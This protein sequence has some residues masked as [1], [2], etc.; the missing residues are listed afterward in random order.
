MSGQIKFFQPF[1]TTKGS[2]NTATATTSSTPVTASQA[3]YNQSHMT[4]TNA[5]T[6]ITEFEE[7]KTIDEW[8]K[9]YQ[10]I[11]LKFILPRRCN[12]EHDDDGDGNGG[13]EDKE[14]LDELYFKTR[15]DFYYAAKFGLI[16]MS[17]A[18]ECVSQTDESLQIS[19]NSE[20]VFSNSNPDTE[21]SENHMD[22]QALHTNILSP[23]DARLAVP[24][25]LPLLNKS[26]NVGRKHANVITGRSIVPYVES[27]DQTV[28]SISDISLSVSSVSIG[29]A[30]I[31]NVW[32][33]QKC[34]PKD[35]TKMLHQYRNENNNSNGRE[36][37]TIPFPYEWMTNGP[38][39]INF[40]R[41]VSFE[42]MELELCQG[43]QQKIRNLSR[44]AFGQK[45][46]R[47]RVFFYNLYADAVTNVIEHAERAMRSAKNEVQS[48]KE[49][50]KDRIVLSL[51]NVPAEC[52]FPMYTRDYW[53]TVRGKPI[54]DE[55]GILSDYCICIGDKSNI[56]YL[57]DNGS[58][59]NFDSDQLEIAILV[60]GE[61]GEFEN[62]FVIN[63][64]VVDEVELGVRKGVLRR[65]NGTI[66]DDYKRV[67]SGRAEPIVEEDDDLA[68][69]EFQEQ[70]HQDQDQEQVQPIGNQH[71][72]PVQRRFATA[73][74]G[75]K[76]K[77]QHSDN[78][79]TV[80]SDIGEIYHRNKDDARKKREVDIYATVL[81]FGAPRQIRQRGWMLSISIFDDTLQLPSTDVSIDAPNPISQVKLVMFA[82]NPD[83]FP[84]FF[85]A[86]D[87]LR[88]HRVLVDVSISVNSSLPLNSKL[89]T[90]AIFYKLTGIRRINSA[91]C[92]CLE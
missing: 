75:N 77:A 8:K 87:V 74:T 32:K 78:R 90:L 27:L 48:K 66:A 44:A 5:N 50:L 60:K 2:S 37:A 54:E 82:D 84:L 55:Y 86:G 53:D 12:Y 71:N 9:L 61:D 17:V 67:I 42:I 29:L 26:K 24:E 21:E 19:G 4:S 25:F 52:I 49:C 85:C 91:D 76:R 38:L 59:L 18:E 23:S 14:L 83:D 40:R 10:K 41:V 15:E 89:L 3:E 62:E 20:R 81:N 51:Q 33:I 68:G 30:S 69:V 63:Q 28:K 31:I 36:A 34:R 79:Y 72:R 80:L 35:M 6:K 46:K 65:E 39:Y 16:P 22:T 58:K 92:I 1:L 73:G 43:N 13:D 57:S 64:M 7:Q 47:I 88:G 11:I 56:T 45:R 70:E